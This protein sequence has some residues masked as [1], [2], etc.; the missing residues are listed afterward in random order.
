MYAD[1]SSNTDLLKIKAYGIYIVFN[2]GFTP[3]PL[4]NLTDSFS[5]ILSNTSSPYFGYFFRKSGSN[6]PEN[7]TSLIS[8]ANINQKW[9][10]YITAYTN[11]A[12]IMA[13]PGCCT[14]M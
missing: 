12:S 14:I 10:E 1:Y 13:P 8:Q 9:N 4:I 5:K 3:P 2:D 11:S 7:F 6:P